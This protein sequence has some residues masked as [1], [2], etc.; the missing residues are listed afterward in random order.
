MDSLASEHTVFVFGPGAPPYMKMFKDLG[1]KSTPDIDKATIICFTGGEDVS[2]ELYGESIFVASNN[3]PSSFINKKRDDQDALVFGFGCAAQVY[4]IGICR[5][6]QFLNVMN[7]GKMWQHVNGH[8]GRGTHQIVD[9][10][11]GEV[12]NVTSTHHQIMRPCEDGVVWA[13]ARETSKREAFEEVWTLA[14]AAERNENTDDIEVVW[15]PETKCL[16]FQ[17]HPEHSG[18]DETLAYFSQLL[19]RMLK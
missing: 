4:M 3:S 6:A 5:G 19:E 18:A 1:F 9:T 10:E 2:P 13:V 14:E 15:Y 16:C 11:T 7:G 8:A 12:V 17:P